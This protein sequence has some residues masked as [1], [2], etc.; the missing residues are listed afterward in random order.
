LNKKQIDSNVSTEQLQAKKLAHN[1]I[2]GSSDRNYR[3]KQ[4]EVKTLQAIMKKSPKAIKKAEMMAVFKLAK[5]VKRR[6][7]KSQRK[8]RQ[9]VTQKGAKT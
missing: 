5:L 7:A 2:K 1:I 3:L 6:W 9:A 4:E 8:V